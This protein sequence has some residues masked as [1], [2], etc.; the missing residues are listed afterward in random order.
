MLNRKA[1][2][3]RGTTCFDPPVFPLS[4]CI[5]YTVK[6]TCVWKSIKSS[7]IGTC[8][9]LPSETPTHYGF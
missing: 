3:T 1:L 2:A 4:P 6:Y 5:N 8:Y 9:F 7:D